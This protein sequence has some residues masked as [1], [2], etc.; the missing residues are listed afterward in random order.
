MKNKI[1]VPENLVIRQE[2]WQL[3]PCSSCTETPCCKNLPLSGLWLERQS[4]FIALLTSSCHEGFFPALKKSGEWVLY[5]SRNCGY[6]DRENGKCLI[7]KSQSQSLICKSYDAHRCWYIDAFSRD[8]YSTLIPFTTE[9]LIWFEKKYSLIENGFSFAPGWQELCESAFDY[10]KGSP[11]P[12]LRD[13]TSGGAFFSSHTLSF[14]KSREE[15]YLFLPPYKR[16]EHASHFELIAFRLGFP[17][18]NLAVSDNVWAFVINTSLCKPK[19]DLV[20]KE[21]YPAIGHRDC[22]YSF[23]SLV[24]ESWP[25][26]ETGEQWVIINRQNL[27]LLKSITA[28]DA[29]GRVKKLPSTSEILYV[30]KYS[31]PDMAA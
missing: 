28:F 16:A 20:R 10:C 17:G 26:S 30:L 13:N 11:F 22:R 4:D 19:M 9:M 8:R 1:S 12:E 2:P 27:E 7:H 25:F 14:R 31:N 5:L 15:K 24:K 29:S 23:E 18:V 6:L 3:S 21:Y